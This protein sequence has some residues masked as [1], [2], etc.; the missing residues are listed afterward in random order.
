MENTL[1]N[2]AKFFAQYLGQKVFWHLEYGKE[3]SIIQSIMIDVKY[4]YLGEGY[5]LKLKSLSMISDGDLLKIAELLSWSSKISESAI[6]TQTKELLQVKQFQT[7]LYRENWSDIVDKIRELGYAH[8]WNGL[9][10]DT[11]LDYGWI[12]LC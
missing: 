7:N 9:S 6:I 1:E 4:H 8:K 3:I 5:C 2:K 11:M 12:I 10:V